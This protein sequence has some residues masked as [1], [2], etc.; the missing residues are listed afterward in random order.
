MTAAKWVASGKPTRLS[1]GA[2]FFYD[3]M[4][5]FFFSWFHIFIHSTGNSR[6]LL[7]TFCE[8]FWFVLFSFYANTSRVGN[9]ILLTF[10]V[11]VAGK[12]PH[13]HR[14]KLKFPFFFTVLGFCVLVVLTEQTAAVLTWLGTNSAQKAR[15]LRQCVHFTGGSSWEFNGWRFPPLFN[16]Y[17]VE[18]RLNWKFNNISQSEFTIATNGQQDDGNVWNKKLHL[19]TLK[20]W[21]RQKFTNSTTRVSCWREVDLVRLWGGRW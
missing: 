11:M 19:W 1:S 3:A 2:P 14:I 9:G 21:V 8:N 5:Q 13:T 12:Q 7:M 18:G 15:R 10:S 6:S 17:S 16:H 4:N 20:K